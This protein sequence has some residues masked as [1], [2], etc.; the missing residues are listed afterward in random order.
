MSIGTYG[1]PWP[2]A[3]GWATSCNTGAYFAAS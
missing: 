1:S 2:H 3:F